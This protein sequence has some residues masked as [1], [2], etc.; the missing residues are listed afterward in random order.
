M[1]AC[2]GGR[3]SRSQSVVMALVLA[4]FAMGGTSMGHAGPLCIKSPEDPFDTCAIQATTFSREGPHVFSLTQRLNETGQAKTAMQGDVTGSIPSIA[5]I[6]GQGDKRNPPKKKERTKTAEKSDPVAADE[7]LDTLRGVVATAIAIHPQIGVARA[8]ARESLAGIANAQSALF[9]KIDAK[10]AG[11]QGFLG[12][13]AGQVSMDQVRPKYAAGS[14]RTELGLTLRYRLFDFGQIAND[15]LSAEAKL[16]ASKMQ[17]KDT[18][19][20]I[21]SQVAIAYLRVLE[22]RETL[23][24]SE[25]NVASLDRLKELIESNERNGNST[26]ADVKRIQARLQDAQT[27]LSDAQADAA[28]ASD[29]FQRLVHQ[30]PGKLKSVAPPA[31][32]VPKTVQDAVAELPRSNAKLLVAAA[33]IR[34]VERDA[35]SQFASNLPKISIETDATTKSYRG[36]TAH[37]D[38]DFRTMLTFT[39]NLVDGGAGSAARRQLLARLEQ[40]QLSYRF[41]FDEAEADLRQFYR[42]IAGARAKSAAIMTGVEAASKARQLYDEQFSGGKRTLFEL[43]DIQASYYQSRRSQISN[44]YDELRAM[45]NVLRSIG[46]LTETI[47]GSEPSTDVTSDRPIPPGQQTEY[48]TLEGL[49]QTN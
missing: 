32:S 36:R 11:G 37:D 41:T 40:Q 39:H 18:I 3:R 9:P 38:L 1:L 20:D 27:V 17:L 15:I 45:F 33:T 47:V 6:K 46:K 31:Q 19:E 48:P 10:V 7:A 8:R 49:G 26:Q 13:A 16:D 14:S 2:S 5:E 21:A 44:R 12:T 28:N 29:R 30:E 4:A 25:E 24:I 34:S 23:E 22:T 42:S 35:D 43:L